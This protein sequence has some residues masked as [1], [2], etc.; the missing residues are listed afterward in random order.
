MEFG[1]THSTGDD[2]RRKTTATETMS[3]A[4]TLFRKEQNVCAPLTFFPPQNDK[5]QIEISTPWTISNAWLLAK[6]C[7]YVSVL[8]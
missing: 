7:A 2:K 8:L 3:S 1:V 4:T 5:N 6:Q